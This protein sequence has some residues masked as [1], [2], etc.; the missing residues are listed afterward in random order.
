MCI[1]GTI[2]VSSLRKDPRIFNLIVPCVREPSIVFKYHDNTYNLLISGRPGSE[3]LRVI[4][5]CTGT[6]LNFWI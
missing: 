5:L 6:F 4:F 2:I 3:I 1:R